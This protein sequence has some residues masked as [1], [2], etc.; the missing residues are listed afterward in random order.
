MAH[1][2][3]KNDQ[4]WT[5]GKGAVWHIG[6]TKD[7]WTEGDELL[8]PA[9]AGRIGWK[10][11]DGAD[12]IWNPRLIPAWAQVDHDQWVKIPGSFHTIRDDMDA[13]NADRFISQGRGTGIGY[14][15][16]TNQDIIDFCDALCA[17]G[18]FVDSCGSL[19]NGRRVFMSMALPKTAEIV[20]EPA[21][22]HMLLTTPH[23]GTACFEAILAQL[24]TVCWNTLQWNRQG[25]Q[26]NVKIRHTW[27]AA[28]RLAEADRIIT[29]AEANFGPSVDIFRRLA[30]KKLSDET[31][32]AFVE[33]FHGE[34]KRGEKA[35]NRVLE[36][37]HG[38]QLGAK[39]AARQGTAWGLV[40]A[41]SQYI[42]T[43]MVIRRHKDEDGMPK[44]AEEA[45]MQSVIF[46]AGAKRRDAVMNKAMALLN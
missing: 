15:L 1:R 28:E 40:N 39:T 12:G 44:D 37:Y 30:L 31:A 2:V 11:K 23:D 43:D 27:K 34:G 13:D 24:L 3:L 46:G 26:T 9:A 33:S 6:E 7:R 20:D 5:K 35:T 45:R 19:M 29:V 36:L 4:G 10:R 41:F 22:C 32:R 17:G 38:A 25:A 21:V 8:T 14:H 42:E 18:A 16:I